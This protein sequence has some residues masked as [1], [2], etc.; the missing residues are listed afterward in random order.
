[1]LVQECS[2]R[3][4]LSGPFSLSLLNFGG[5]A[6]VYLG[7]NANTASL[8]IQYLVP[9]MNGHPR[10]QAKVSL[11]DRWPLVGGTGGRGCQT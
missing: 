11:N 6:E 7:N 1:M 9:V 3:L 4:T 2:L 10:E 8:H 5:I